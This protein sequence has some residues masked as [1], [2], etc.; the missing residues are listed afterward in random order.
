MKRSKAIF[1]NLILL[2]AVSLGMRF[3]TLGF[4]VYITG[5]IGAQGIGLYS[6]IMSVG[7]FS[8]TFATSG[9]NLGATRLTAEALGRGS[10]RDVRRAMRVCIIYSTFFGVL[11]CILLFLSATPLSIH[12]LGD[13]RCIL[14]LKVLS[15]GLPFISLSSALSGYFTAVRRVIKNSAVQVTQQFVNIAIT[16]RLISLL[17]PKGIEYAC[18]AVILGSALSEFLAFG[19]SFTVYLLDIRWHNSNQGSEEERL[20]KKLLSVSLPV[21]FS[22]YV[23][24]GLVSIEHILIPKGLKKFGAGKDNALASYGTLHGMAMPVIL[25]P[26]AIISSFAGLLV[27]EI[28]GSLAAGEIKRVD[29]MVTRSIRLTLAYGV[30]CAG[31]MA[32][33]GDRLGDILYK[34]PDAG[35]F[36]RIMAPLIPV[37]YFDHIVDGML[38]GL[39]EQLYSMRV[40][41]ID[42]LLSVILVYFLVPKWGIFGYAFIIYAMEIINAS[43]SVT[44]LLQ[45]CD[46]KI[47]IFNWVI[48][49]VICIIGSAS[50]QNI[51]SKNI[52]HGSCWLD[53][54]LNVILYILFLR[55]TYSFDKQD[56][57]W[58]K[59]AVTE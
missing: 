12:I 23:R 36:I 47:S 57:I 41:I 2:T 54:S 33:F 30:G 55:L 16:T 25:F 42:S 6:L 18:I 9:V 1:Y 19:C 14:P 10:Q 52:L 59:N 56:I 17:M 26:M 28:A 24:S 21:A 31:I 53:I 3:V 43:L 27:P 20:A 46:L 58:F 50:L 4:N 48:K 37:M 11:G 7:G 38:K 39:G 29:N 22:A 45:R 51:I 8:I 32:A 34:N 40:N 44:R 49:P 15:F 5:K 35:M 13:K